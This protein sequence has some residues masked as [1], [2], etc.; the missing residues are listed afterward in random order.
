MIG[1]RRNT[2]DA[3]GNIRRELLRPHL[4]DLHLTDLGPDTV[5]IHFLD[6]RKAMSFDELCAA[7]WKYNDQENEER[8]STESIAV[9]LVKL[10]E[11]DMVSIEKIEPL[12][13]S[14]QSFGPG[15]TPRFNIVMHSDYNVD[16]VIERLEQAGIPVDRLNAGSYGTPKEW[17]K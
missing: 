3:S 12:S 1:F 4:T 9:G 5:V 14:F 13:I 2:H 6:S 8:Q 11:H 17:K 16:E 15:E 10:I 7:T